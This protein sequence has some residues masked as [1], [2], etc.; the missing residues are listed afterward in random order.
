[1]IRRSVSIVALMFVNIAD[2][3]KAIHY[4]SEKIEGFD[5]RLGEKSETC[6]SRISLYYRICRIYLRASLVYR[7]IKVPSSIRASY[8]T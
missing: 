7:T 5:S 2:S 3:N 4:H 8:L 1:M 6:E